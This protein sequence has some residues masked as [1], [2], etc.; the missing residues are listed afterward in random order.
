MPSAASTLNVFISSTSEDLKPY[1]A[2]AADAIRKVGW[3]PVMMEDFGA[4]AQ[5]TVSACH[6]KLR[7]CQLVL[8]IQAFRRGWVP[9]VAEGGNGQ[10]SV[11]ALELAFAR[12]PAQAIP[13]L[14]LLAKPAWPGDL[15]DHD[16]AAYQWVQQFRAGL[17]QPAAFFDPEPAEGPE[18]RRLPLFRALVQTALN[19]H[20]Q[21]LLQQQEHGAGGAGIDFFE[22]ARDMLLNRRGVV[23]FIGAGIF[24]DDALGIGPL[25]RALRPEGEK[26]DFGSLAEVAE[27]RQRL[28]EERPAFLDRLREVIEA[29][30][31]GAATPR[32]VEMLLRLPQLPLVVACSHD[33]VLEDALRHENPPRRFVVVSHVIQ[34]AGG[35][36]DGK[37]AVFREDEPPEFVPAD[38]WVPRAGERGDQLVVYRPLGSPLLNDRADPEL[39]LDTVVITENDHLT[40]FGRLENQAK[41]IPTAFSLPLQTKPLVFMGYGLDVWHF[42]L[43][44]QMFQVAGVG[45]KHAP[46]VAV[47]EPASEMEAL[48][49]EGLRIRLVR[50]DPAQFAERM[51]PLLP[52]RNVP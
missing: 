38:K 42:R 3:V 41:S 27:Y 13:V 25:M 40:F 37:I 6:D 19:N 44:M 16:P 51:L 31:R 4:I 32:V 45:P 20:R 21:S 24:G 15:W 50:M 36:H 22:S 18:D 9:S 29:Q 14:V 48:A 49:W 47:R 43:V 35:Q 28:L 12:D 2:A 39:G 30:S 46:F 7:G 8:L 52:A 34:S 10:D 33:Q 26:N 23:P 11:T 1:R 5:R 17:N